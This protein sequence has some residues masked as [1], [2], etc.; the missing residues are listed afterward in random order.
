MVLN[1]IAPLDS[2]VLSLDFEQINVFWTSGFDSVSI[3]FDSRS[4]IR[5][6]PEMHFSIR[7]RCSFFW[8]WVNH[9]IVYGFDSITIAQKFHT[10]TDY[11]K[12]AC[13]GVSVNDNY[14]FEAIDD[15][16]SKKRHRP[17]I[18]GV[19]NY[20]RWLEDGKNWKCF[21]GSF[22]KENHKLEE[23]VKNCQQNV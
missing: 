2:A 9:F 1:P 4:V 10:I 13:T 21:V 3:L 8:L 16:R 7:F 19:L 18:K 14:I 11:H 20:V 6:L 22:M 23:G 12:M 15:I 17:D 5:R